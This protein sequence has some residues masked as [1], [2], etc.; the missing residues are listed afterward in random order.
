MQVQEGQAVSITPQYLSFS[1][2]KSPEHITYT[3]TQPLGPYDGSLFNID[4][5]GLELRQ[6]TQADIND[7]KIIY[8][9]PLGDIGDEDKFFSFKFVGIEMF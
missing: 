1:G 9:P 8:M 6:F 4:S 2:G 5:P 3:I 7:M